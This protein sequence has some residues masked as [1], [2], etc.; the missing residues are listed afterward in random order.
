M[1]IITTGPPR[2]GSKGGVYTAASDASSSAHTTHISHICIYIFH[3]NSTNKIEY[4]ITFHMTSSMR[5]CNSRSCHTV[6]CIFA[7][8]IYEPHSKAWPSRYT[9]MLYAQWAKALSRLFYR[10]RT[11]VRG[12]PL[13]CAALYGHSRRCCCC[14]P[15][16]WHFPFILHTSYYDFWNILN[17]NE[18]LNPLKICAECWCVESPVPVGFAEA[19]TRIPIWYIFVYLYLCVHYRFFGTGVWILHGPGELRQGKVYKISTADDKKRS[20]SYECTYMYMNIWPWAGAQIHRAPPYQ[21]DFHFALMPNTITV[22]NNTRIKSLLFA[23]IY[24]YHTIPYHTDT[25][26]KILLTCFLLHTHFSILT[27]FA[28]CSFFFFLFT[29]LAWCDEAFVD[30][31]TVT[32]PSQRLLQP[33]YRF[34]ITLPRSFN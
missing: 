15:E 21:H 22:T 13:L 33:P 18:T 26:P 25:I 1:S 12:S 2:P 4:R 28:D 34:L 30:E 17:R 20:I 3:P 19:T 31:N 11:S 6:R 9:R 10:W 29:F 8:V 5:T 27:S 32:V 7:G 14:G 24:M 16:I 23:D